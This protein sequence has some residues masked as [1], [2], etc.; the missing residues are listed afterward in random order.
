[1]K[2]ILADHAGACY[3]VRRALE[4]AH[5]AAVEPVAAVEPG[6]VEPAAVE[7]A[8]NQ[9]PVFTLGPLIHNPV[10]VS[11]LESQ[12]IRSVRTPEE[13]GKGVL[14]VRSHGVTPDVYRRARACGLQ[15]IDATCPHVKRAQNAAAQ[16]ASDYSFV[17]VVGEEGHPEVAGLR[18][19]ACEA[20]ASVAVA[21]QAQDLPEALPEELGVVV[22]TTQTH[23]AFDQVMQELSR[24]GIKAHARDT[25]CFAT[26]QRQEA[27]S[28]LAR[29][30]DAVVVI[31]GKNSSNTTRLKEICSTYCPRVYHVETLEE[32]QGKDFSQCRSVGVTAGASTPE[33]QIR[34][35]VEQLERL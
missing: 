24:R 28:R 30:V 18:A 7:P 20:G 19:Y 15:L 16:L 34:L 27:A 8:G 6:G 1:M 12:G 21:A 32:L 13:A 3:G 9:G 2:V 25:I 11:E 5:A 29:T 17:V 35:V 10:V 14:I 31:G 4:I 22:Q 26:Q 23:Q 33:S